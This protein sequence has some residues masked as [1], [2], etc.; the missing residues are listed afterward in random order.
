MITTLN[1]QDK[2]FQIVTSTGNQVFCNMEDIN[3]VVKEYDLTEGYFTIYS[4]WN[5][6]PKKVGKGAL[7]EMFKANNIEQQFY[8]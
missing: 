1:N 6:K 3:K 5:N 8:Y 7:K 4:F 2:I